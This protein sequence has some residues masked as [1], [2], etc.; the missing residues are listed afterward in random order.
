[1][2]MGAFGNIWMHMHAYGHIWVMGAFGGREKE[3]RRGRRERG[4]R[5]R[6]TISAA[7]NLRFRKGLS[8]FSENYYRKR[9]GIWSD[10]MKNP[11]K[12]IGIFGTCRPRPHKK[13]GKE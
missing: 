13:Q 4:D 5:E 10:P 12:M 8:D 9:H 1:M 7:Q 6:K 11:S 2:H 3:E